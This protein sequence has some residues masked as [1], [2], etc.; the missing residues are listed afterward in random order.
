MLKKKSK[1]VSDNFWKL[2]PLS[3]LWIL[4]FEIKHTLLFVLYFNLDVISLVSPVPAN[5]YKVSEDITVN[6]G[7][8][9]TLSCLA[10]GRPDPVITWR[11]LNPSGRNHPIGAHFHLCQS[12]R[13]AN[14][15]SDFFIILIP[16][17]CFFMLNQNPSSCGACY[18]IFKK[19]KKI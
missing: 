11:L 9:M 7:S 19:L 15:V 12:R 17:C 5:I 18:I 16:D 6:E 10:S 8:N 14:G 13:L 2:R 4:L 3:K 1:N